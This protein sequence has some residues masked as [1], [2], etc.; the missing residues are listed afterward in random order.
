MDEVKELLNEL[1]RKVDA[2]AAA[3]ASLEDITTKRN[4]PERERADDSKRRR[5]ADDEGGAAPAAGAGSGTTGGAVSDDFQYAWD[6]A[7]LIERVL[8]T[9]DNILHRV[10]ELAAE[11]S[12]S[13]AATHESQF[14]VVGLLSGV[15]MFMADLVR[16]LT[17][18]HQVD[19]VAA[20][21]YGLET[22]SSAN[23]KIKK[24]TEAPVEGKDV[25]VV[26]EMC[27]SGRTMAS[28]MKLFHD[29]GAKSVRSCVLLDKKE[30]RS[31]AVQP[32]FVGFICPDEF[33][34]GYGM[35]W[36]QRFRSLGDICVVKR[37]AYEK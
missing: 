31:V 29:R 24:D 6:S 34:V 14:V 18:P 15:F 17:V 19:F 4:L 16:Q 30:R 28:L 32:D 36:A 27:D 22:V 13:Y 21:S 2:Q 7:R 33:V 3:L 11:I 5:R 37:S 8:F 25:L 10:R 23:V 20:S 26:D 35:D 12:A 1:N 9:Q